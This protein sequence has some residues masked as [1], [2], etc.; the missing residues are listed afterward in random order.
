MN[1][2][3]IT[4]EILSPIEQTRYPI[5]LDA[6]LFHK[7]DGDFKL[8]DSVLAKDENGIYRASSM[9]Y[10]QTPTHIVSGL[11]TAHPTRTNWPDFPYQLQLNKR[12]NWIIIKGGP[13]RKKLT[14]R[15]GLSTPFVQFHAVGDAD[16]IR[17]LLSNLGFIGGSYNQGFGQIGAI[18]IEEAE[19]DYS[20][21]DEDG[22][23]AR[24]LPVSLVPESEKY[25]TQQ[26]R[27]KPNYFN[28]ELQTC[29]IP[30]FRLKT[31]E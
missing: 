27:F 3:T 20:F 11:S 5:H 17:Y 8:L 2:L 21:F 9:R 4:L 31:V 18:E 24:I 28:S 10:L 30:N 29:S 6:L 16:K 23:L 19:C 14:K 26:A 13:Y 7:L 12:S 1:D 22:E 25:L 15:N